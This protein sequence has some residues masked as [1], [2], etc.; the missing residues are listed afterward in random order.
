MPVRARIATVEQAPVVVSGWTMYDN[1]GRGVVMF[2]PYADTGLH[3]RRPPD[4]VLG[5]LARTIRHFDPRGVCVRTVAPDR[6]E[7]C[8]VP[9]VPHDL[10]DPTSYDPTPWETYSYD[11]NDNAGRTHPTTSLGFSLHWNTPISSRLDAFGRTI[12]QTVHAAE[13]LTTSMS[14][15]I[16]GRRLSTTDPLGRLCERTVY[17]LTGGEWRTWRMDAGTTWT[18][19]DASGASVERRDERRTVALSSYDEAQRPRHEWA[20]DRAWPGGH[21]PRRRRLR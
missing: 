6:S 7:T 18:V 16:E 9:G 12:V 14:Y 15:D 13:P 11:G 19:R 21:S 3:Y 4:A 2:E 10:A 8:T 5:G 20:S 17:D 1:K